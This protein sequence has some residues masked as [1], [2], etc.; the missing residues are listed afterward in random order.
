MAYNDT[1]QERA[2]LAEQCLAIMDRFE[3]KA[4]DEGEWA[5]VDPACE[6][7]D[8]IVLGGFR[9]AALAKKKLAIMKAAMAAEIKAAA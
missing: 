6:D 2:A 1:P 4:V 5:I 7:D 8:P 9:L 3:V